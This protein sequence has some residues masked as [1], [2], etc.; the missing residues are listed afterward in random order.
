MSKKLPPDMLKQRADHDY[1]SWFVILPPGFEFNDLF[2]PTFFSHHKKL[3]KNDLIR[4]KGPDFDCTFEVVAA[5]QGGAQIDVWPRYPGG[6]NIDA[7]K[8]AAKEAANSRSN[9]VPILANG[10]TAIRVDHT[11]ASKW[12]VIALDQT[13]LKE[14]FETKGEAQLLMAS[15]LRS[16]GMVLPSDEDIAAAVEKA[17]EAQ[18]ERVKPRK[19]EAA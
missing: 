13:T 8:A 6:A 5:P 15:Y 10:K 19:T 17:K 2:S 12:R 9:I 3:R 18:K 4:V 16:L 14:G 1:N 7:A 11:T